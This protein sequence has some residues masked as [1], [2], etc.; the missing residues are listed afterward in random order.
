MQTSVPVLKFKHPVQSEASMN[1][2]II[3]ALENNSSYNL[4]VPAFALNLCDRDEA[5]LLIFEW[6]FLGN[7]PIKI[8]IGCLE[9]KSKLMYTVV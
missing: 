2:L 5:Q 6:V 4:R 9:Q 8:M 1:C 7:K 3:T